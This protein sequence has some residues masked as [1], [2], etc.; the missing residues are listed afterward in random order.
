MAINAPNVTVL[1]RNDIAS[2]IEAREFAEL[3]ITEDSTGMFVGRLA[4]ARYLLMGTIAR[5]HAQEWLLTGRIIDAHTGEIVEGHPRRP[6]SPV[7]Q[8]NGKTATR[9][10]ATR[11]GLHTPPGQS[12][13]PVK[14]HEQAAPGTV[15]S[16]VRAVPREGP[17]RLEINPIPNQPLYTQGENIRFQV[18]S[19]RG[20]YLTL[21][22]VGPTGA[23]T[24]LVPNREARSVWLDRGEDIVIPS[25]EMN[26]IFPVKPP[27]G[28]TRI[29]AFLTPEP[30][31]VPGSFD[32]QRDLLLKLARESHVGPAGGDP[33]ANPGWTTRE[34][35][36]MTR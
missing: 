15:E 26:F 8:G 31:V 24:L 27:H 12:P 19:D 32:D 3:D 36:F 21:F 35:S 14:L 6:W 23:V 2:I 7:D 5:S 18:Q 13:Q 33:L 25:P 22:S 10:L 9:Q 1:E 11:M 20:G 28:L 30:L 16:I 4:N 34:I 29:K 17:V